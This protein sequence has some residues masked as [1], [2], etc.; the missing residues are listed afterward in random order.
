MFDRWTMVAALALALRARPTLP[1]GLAPA[2]PLRDRQAEKR[3]ALEKATGAALASALPVRK[4][5]WVPLRKGEA[6]E[7]YSETALKKVLSVVAKPSTTAQPTKSSR[8]K[9]LNAMKRWHKA[10]AAAAVPTALATTAPAG[11]RF[12]RRGEFDLMNGAYRCYDAAEL[13]STVLD[14]HEKR[15][16]W[17]EYMKLYDENKARVPPTAIKNILYPKPKAMANITKLRESGLKR[18]GGPPQVTPA[19]LSNPRRPSEIRVVHT[20]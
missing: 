1:I 8:Q 19:S 3:R 14:L 4:H 7:L 11:Q 6:T 17:S 20:H 12:M 5:D 2:G 16:K 15:I 10:D 9:R 13:L 18:L